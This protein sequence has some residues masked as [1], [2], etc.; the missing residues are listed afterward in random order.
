MESESKSKNKNESKSKIKSE[1]KSE[2]K[3]ETHIAAC[4]P[5]LPAT[6]FISVTLPK[7]LSTHFSLQHLS[8]SKISS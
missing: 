7:L 8:Y 4:S 6:K 3:I 5:P 2:S 1:S